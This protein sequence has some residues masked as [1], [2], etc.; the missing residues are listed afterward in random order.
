MLQE[1][2]IDNFAIIPHLQI[3]FNQGMTVLSG[4][5]GAGK[6]II[7]D[8]VGLLAGGRGSQE[9]IRTGSPKAVLQAAFVIDA[10]NQKLMQV[11][12]D[13]GI[14]VSD[15]QLII[16]REIHRSGRN[17]IRVNGML[18]NLT[19]LKQ[20]GEFL[21]DIHGQNEHQEL[22][23][24][25]K[26]LA[27]LDEYVGSQLVDLKDQYQ[28]T[29]HEYRQVLKA[30]NE[31]QQNQQAWAQRFDMLKFQVEEL[32][33]AA[34]T[35]GEED[36]LLAERSRLNNFQK[37][38]SAL[39]LVSI[40]LSGDEAAGAL[41]NLGEAMQA[42]QSIENIDESYHEIS[43]T[44]DSSFYALQEIV[45][46]VSNQI[47]LLEYDEE[48]LNQ[49]EQ[50]LDLIHQLERKYGPDV[51]AMLAYLT[52]IKAEFTKMENVSANSD[53][54]EEQLAAITQQLQKRGA[55]LSALRQASAVTLA[56]KIHQQ[57]KDLY[58]EKARFSV[59]FKPRTTF[60]LDGIDEVEFYIQTNPGETAKPLAKIASGGELSRMMLAMK[61]IF[62]Q[63]QGV[64]SI[65][66][67][68]VDTGVS[69]RVAQAIAEKI[70]TIADHSQV[71][72]IT[73]LPQ[74][75]AM[76]DQHYLIQKTVINERTET[77]INL[78]DEQQRARE[79]ARMI[80]GAEVTDLSLAN[81]TELLALANSKKKESHA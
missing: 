37:I 28:Q 62:A 45:K 7:I 26:H 16:Q 52:K 70:A 48:R 77:S 13:L 11:L 15:E 46:D 6:S 75:A 53:Q 41:D 38:M 17:V 21:V 69:G 33:D 39:E 74:V 60:Q 1:L 23:Q 22:M 44:I 72:T 2:S 29:F 49:I 64:T 76:A 35:I 54:L 56:D 73:H 34:L 31:K 55:A 12:A 4:E 65:V 9:F 81:A 59:N 68:E 67:D 79:L 10:T 32:E 58:M 3:D 42:M 30:V 24:P 8:A 19:T 63:N 51:E 40:K 47:D 66:F 50:R 43:E 27:M 14:E 18:L 78:L 80:S 61:T 25:E 20:V 36:Q 57:L 71:L 5:T